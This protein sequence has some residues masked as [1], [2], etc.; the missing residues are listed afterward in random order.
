MKYYSSKHKQ[1]GFTLIELVV[2]IAILAILAAFAL[3]RF[4]QLS[5]QAHQASIQGTAGALSAGVALTKA[6]WVANGASADAAARTNL[7]GF[8]NEVIEVSVE[9]WP[10]ATG[11]YTGAADGS[12]TMTPGRCEDVWEELLQSNAPSVGAADTDYIA[13]V[14]STS[15]CRFTYNLDGQNSYIEY[16]AA[17]GD[18]ATVVN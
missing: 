18:I 12:V 14:N 6:Q 3:P 8:G 2:V 7:E 10:V 16:N 1:K 9:G 17:D 4:A 5:E 13:S 11:G 15:V